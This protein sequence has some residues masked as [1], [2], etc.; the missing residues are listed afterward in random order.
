MIQNEIK[1][2][3]PLALAH[4]VCGIQIKVQ[5]E[6]TFPNVARETSPELQRAYNC[7]NWHSSRKRL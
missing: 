6:D 5:F 1:R 3:P 2:D 4:W 7:V